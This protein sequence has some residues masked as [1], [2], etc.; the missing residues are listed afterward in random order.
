MPLTFGSLLRSL[1]IKAGYGLRRFAEI[2]EMQASNLSNIEND[3]R[4]P[5]DDEDKL[6]EIAATLGL[7]EDSVEWGDLFDAA[8]RSGELPADVRKTADRRLIPVL[9]RT[10]DNCNLTDA[11]LDKLIKDVETKYGD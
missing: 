9:L 5:P 2:I 10:I 4:P 11:Q 8:R 6:R 1:R 7:S 3:R